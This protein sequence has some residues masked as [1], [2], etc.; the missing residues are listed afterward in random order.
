MS[1][2]GS[3]A[4]AFGEPSLAA[5][6]GAAGRVSERGFTLFE[7]LVV[8]TIIAM[9]MGSMSLLYRKPSGAALAKAAALATASHL[10]DVRATAMSHGSERR[11]DIIPSKGLLSFD[12]GRADVRLDPSI[13]IAITSADSERRSADSAGIKFFPNGSSTGATITLRS[14]QHSYEVR[15]NWL[16]GRVSAGAL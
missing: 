12:T 9:A 16:T 14:D 15:V 4:R 11:V 8:M 13:Q 3:S 10:R 1:Q 2:P 7:M 5:R 6:V